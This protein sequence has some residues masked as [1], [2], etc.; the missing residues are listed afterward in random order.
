MEPLDYH[1]PQI[2][3]LTVSSHSP[4]DDGRDG[5]GEGTYQRLFDLITCHRV[6]D[7]VELAE[8]SGL[9]RLSTLL[10]QLDGDGSLASLILRQLELWKHN[11]G[12]LSIHPDLLRLY[13]LIG[14]NFS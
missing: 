14:N 9:F 1:L 10:S 11:G 12:D 2:P 6:E 8:K 13:R 7:A 5:R 4:L 3:F